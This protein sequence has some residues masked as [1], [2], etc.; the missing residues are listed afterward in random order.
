MP[1]I[2][3]VKV[4]FC[5]CHLSFSGT[6][7]NSNIRW[8]LSSWTVEGTMTDYWKQELF[9]KLVHRLKCDLG[10]GIGSIHWQKGVERV[11]VTY[12]IC[13]TRTQTYCFPQTT[14]AL[15]KLHWAT[16]FS[17]QGSIVNSL[18]KRHS[19]SYFHVARNDNILLSHTHPNLMK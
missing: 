18:L 7:V 3:D 10:C 17:K 4:K 13:N 12:W 14:S 9:K 19:R 8:D 5:E 1:A 2:L 6:Q 16:W 11:C 15:V